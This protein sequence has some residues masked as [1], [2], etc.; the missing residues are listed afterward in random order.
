MKSLLP[1]FNFLPSLHEHFS[2]T[3][4]LIFCLNFQLSFILVAQEKVVIF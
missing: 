3:Y 4:V 2:A 1:T